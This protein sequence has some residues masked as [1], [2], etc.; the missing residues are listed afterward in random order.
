MGYMKT[1]WLTFFVITFALR[2]NAALTFCPQENNLYFHDCRGA[3]YVIEHRIATDVYVVR[4][5]TEEASVFGKRLLVQVN[6]QYDD[7]VWTQSLEG[8]FFAQARSTKNAMVVHVTGNRDTMV[9]SSLF[10]RSANGVWMRQEIPHG[11]KV[12]DNW[13]EDYGYGILTERKCDGERDKVVFMDCEGRLTTVF[14]QPLFAT[15]PQVFS[16]GVIG[17]RLNEGMSFQD[18]LYMVSSM[19]LYKLPKGMELLSFGTIRRVLVQTNVGDEPRQGFFD[20]V[21][22]EFSPLP[23]GVR[24]LGGVEGAQ[25]V[26]E[27]LDNAKIFGP[28]WQ[29]VVEEAGRYGVTGKRLSPYHLI[30]V[31]DPKMLRIF[32][33]TAKWE[34]S[35]EKRDVVWKGKGFIVVKSQEGSLKVFDLA[36]DKWQTITIQSNEKTENK[37]SHEIN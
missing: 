9:S 13:W 4:L 29:P 36:Q 2:L 30:Y 33:L 35:T 26:G 19:R 10:L 17:Y 37:R 34:F 8:K 16:N 14:H 22:G 20:P 15:E 27:W 18:C 23:Q 31:E 12:K 32:N 5:T 11:L 24:F 1:P 6:H 25:R 7:F 28:D 21:E 3:S